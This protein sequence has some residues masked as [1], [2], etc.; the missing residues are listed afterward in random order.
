Q[1]FTKINTSCGTN[2]D[3]TP[4][5]IADISDNTSNSDIYQESLTQC[6]ASPICTK[7]K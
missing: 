6:S 4:E 3:N 2:S 7:S 5:Q 1:S